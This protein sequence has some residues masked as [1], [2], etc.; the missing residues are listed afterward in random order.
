MMSWGSVSI[1][2]SLRV[3]PLADHRGRF[4]RAC[5]D[6]FANALESGELDAA[7]DLS[8]RD[9]LIEQRLV[10]VAHGFELP[11]R[12]VVAVGGAFGECE[13]L[14]GLGGE[15][16]LAGGALERGHCGLRHDLG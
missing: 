11:H 12:V 1:V 6:R 13:H 8:E 9:L 5:M 16:S 3:H 15:R 10:A 7:V 2:K 4:W 14:G